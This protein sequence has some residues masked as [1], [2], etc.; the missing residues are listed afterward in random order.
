MGNTRQ[1]PPPDR[2]FF[3]LCMIGPLLS[4]SVGGAPLSLSIKLKITPYG[5][6]ASIAV[7][8]SPPRVSASAS[9]WYAAFSTMYRQ[10]LVSNVSSGFCRPS[11][12][13]TPVELQIFLLLHRYCSLRRAAKQK[14]AR[15]AR[16]IKGCELHTSLPTK[17]RRAL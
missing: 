8:Y 11:C 4:R 12:H 7:P 14:V 9:I 17:A 2:V 3:L 13:F 16:L 15:V 6:E 1:V 10:F 5:G